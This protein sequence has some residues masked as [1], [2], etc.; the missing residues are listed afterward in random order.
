MGRARGRSIGV[1][2]TIQ[3]LDRRLSAEIGAARAPLIEGLRQAAQ[4]PAWHYL[5]SGSLAR[6][7]ARRGSDADIAVVG[8]TGAGR[9]RAP[10]A[11]SA[12]RWA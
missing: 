12:R 10:P 3:A 8:A 4:G 1:M 2:T 6:D 9:R 11:P 5:L 7:S